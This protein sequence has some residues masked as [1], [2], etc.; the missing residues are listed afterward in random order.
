MIVGFPLSF[1]VEFIS[2]M[3]A[4]PELLDEL[5]DLDELAELARGSNVEYLGVNEFDTELP[6]IDA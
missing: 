1:L 2:D 4:A 5:R 3:L 6:F